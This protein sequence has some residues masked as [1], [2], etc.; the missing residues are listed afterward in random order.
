MNTKYNNDVTINHDTLLMLPIDSQLTKPV[1]INVSL[2]SVEILA[3]QGSD[4]YNAYLQ[5]TFVPATVRS[6]IEQEMI[7]Q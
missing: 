3:D 1:S 4:P 7:Q 2:D 5:S 6:F